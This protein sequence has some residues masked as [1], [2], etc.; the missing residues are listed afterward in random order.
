MPVMAQLLVPGIVGISTYVDYVYHL[1]MQV[2]A[3]RTAGT[4]G[5][6]NQL[7]L[8]TATLDFHRLVEN[9]RAD[10][11]SEAEEQVAVAAAVLEAGGADFLVV[12]SGT[13]STLTS[14]ARGRV[15]LAFLDLA[16]AAWDE[17]GGAR[18]VGLLSTR[19]TVEGG[20]FQV[21]AERRGAT[22]LLP[23]P[24]VAARLDEVIFSELVQGRVTTAAVRL[25]RDAAA[26]LS[27]EGAESIILG[28]TDMTLA[29]GQLRDFAVPLIDS[30]RAHA[31][32]SA[33]AALHGLPRSRGFT[34]GASA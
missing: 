17:A 32:A 1:E 11:L 15:S 13:T 2:T 31:R 4:V 25:L 18:R 30:A 14:R 19:R 33:R 9:L 12:T 28:N 7:R 34:A 29:A 10:R 27:R 21:A 23:P 26:G 22:L 24:D 8:I 6:I 20:I 16:E 5:P 3:T